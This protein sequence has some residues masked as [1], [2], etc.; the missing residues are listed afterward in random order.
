MAVLAAMPCAAEAMTCAVTSATLPA[1]Q[2]PG[3]SVRPVRGN[4]GAPDGAV[5]HPVDRLDAQTGEQTG[6][7]G[8]PGRHHEDPAG[9]RRI[10]ARISVEHLGEERF[11]SPR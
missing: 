3:T 2:T 7:G 5:H 8:E 10:R 9:P 11:A 1:T 6:I 4:A